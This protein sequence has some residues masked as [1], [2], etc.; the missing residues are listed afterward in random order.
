M[1]LREALESETVTGAGYRE[2]V[3]VAVDAPVRE[4]IATMREHLKSD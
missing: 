4:A 1:E 2:P 3:T